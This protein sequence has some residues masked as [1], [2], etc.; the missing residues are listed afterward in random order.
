[1]PAT[2]VACAILS[3]VGNAASARQRNLTADADDDDDDDD[4]K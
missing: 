4:D 2:Q 1:M 3:S